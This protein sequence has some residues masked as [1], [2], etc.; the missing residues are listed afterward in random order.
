M[1]GCII[2]FKIWV[3]REIRV[4]EGPENTLRKSELDFTFKKH[5]KLNFENAQMGFSP[6]WCG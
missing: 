2:P 4:G 1:I 3:Q 5:P 6:P